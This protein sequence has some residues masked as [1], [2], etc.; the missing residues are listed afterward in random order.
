LEKLKLSDLLKLKKPKLPFQNQIK[1]QLLEILKQELLKLER[2]VKPQ[3]LQEKLFLLMKF[4]L[5]L[6]KLQKSLLIKKY[7]ETRRCW[8][9][10]AD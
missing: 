10:S 2:L 8:R 4:E 3:R 9:G 1:T 6:L 7:A 5:L